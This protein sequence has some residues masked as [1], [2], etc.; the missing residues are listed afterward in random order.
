MVPSESITL[1][2]LQIIQGIG[3]FLEFLNMSKYN[4]TNLTI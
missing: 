1:N 4:N 2:E 3:D